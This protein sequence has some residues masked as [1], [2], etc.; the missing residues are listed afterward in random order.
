MSTWI[1]LSTDKVHTFYRVPIEVAAADDNTFFGLEHHPLDLDGPWPL[2][3]FLQDSAHP[4]VVMFHIFS[5]P[6]EALE[7]EGFNPLADRGGYLSLER[8]ELVDLVSLL[9]ACAQRLPPAHKSDQKMFRRI[10]AS[11]LAD[12]HLHPEWFPNTKR[13]HYYQVYDPLAET[14]ENSTA[15]I[16][17]LSTGHTGPPQALSNLYFKIASFP[18]QA[19][20]NPSFTPLDH[21]LARIHLDRSG[22]QELASLL[23]AQLDHLVGS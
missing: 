15:T 4:G 1:Q 14:R 23:Q 20:Q 16:L 11:E 8:Q 2:L 22:I 12:L 19:L 17:I 10:E 21:S 5:I 6:P 3:A 13:Y 7:F 9:R 18:L